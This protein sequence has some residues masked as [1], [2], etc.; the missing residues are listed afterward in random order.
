[1]NNTV[2]TLL[3][4][5]LS[6]IAMFMFFNGRK[7]AEGT[8][9]ALAL[10]AAAP[11]DG[12]APEQRFHVRT[13]LTAAGSG[14][15]ATVT[16]RSGAL[17]ALDVLGAQFQ[18]NGRPLNLTS[19]DKENTL[20]LYLRTRVTRDGQAVVPPYV[21][22]EGRQVD[23]H[24]VE[25]T[26]RGNDVEVVRTIR[27]ARPFVL[28]VETRVTNHGGAVSVKAQLPVYE[29]V[30]RD[31]DESG[32]IENAQ[33]QVGEAMCR[34]GDSLTREA[35]TDLVKR[36]AGALLP[37]ASRFAAVGNLYFT[38]A[39]APA[40]NDAL[41]HLRR[42]ARRASGRRPRRRG[43]RGRPLLGASHARA[44]PDRD[45]HRATA[46][47]GPKE[48]SLLRAAAADQ[49]LHE[50]VNLG[51]FSF[52]AR[53]LVKVLKFFFGITHNWGIAIIL[54]TLC[55]RIVLLPLL[56]SSMRSMVAMQRIKPSSTRSRSASA[57]TRRPAPSR[58]W[59]CTRST[60]STPCRGACRS[61]RGSRSGG[62]STPTLQFR[63]WSC[64][65]RP[66]RC[67]GATLS[68]PDPFYVLPL[69]LGAIMFV[70]QK[71]MP[72][73][74]MDPVQ[75]KMMTYFFPVFLTVISLMLPSG[76]ALYM[77]CNSLLGIGQ[78][79]YV[80][81]Q[82][83]QFRGGGGGDPSGIVVKPAGSGS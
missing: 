54:L 12:R 67:G 83:D 23:G 14:L 69:V 73:Q 82:M 30:L 79:W 57:T 29:Y 64:S 24:Q 37:G 3:I 18:V 20:P 72:P 1:M 2:R 45:G 6:A 9:A 60:R 35:R 78:Q 25:L 66:S 21:D 11:V 32:M 70:Q 53:Q 42:G 27:G 34:H 56:Q 61:S 51:F 68:A 43:V 8:H 52:I 16:T 39:L 63:R 76:L 47:F 36:D 33:W 55:V 7:G 26:W 58:R 28:E 49:R 77:L 4:V 40:D 5:A 44:R 74:G 38:M 13:A 62:R 19:T 71:L 31:H 65:T 81:R 80:K 75:A 10:E 41:P 48:D 17:R 46:Y 22:F 59:S 50:T 15:D